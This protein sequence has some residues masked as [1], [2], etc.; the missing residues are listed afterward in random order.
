MGGG[1]TS[2]AHQI[3]DVLGLEADGEASDDHRA[4]RDARERGQLV[5]L[6]AVPLER[7]QG[8]D[9]RRCEDA[10]GGGGGGA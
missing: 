4:G 6:E 9:V 1:G 2:L 7:E 8:P 10:W 3:V 5:V